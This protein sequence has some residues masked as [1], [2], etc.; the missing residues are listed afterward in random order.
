M[1]VFQPERRVPASHENSLVCAKL[2]SVHQDGD[3]CENVSAAQTIQVEQNIT[4]MARELYA[5]VSCA[6]HFVKFCKS[7]REKVIPA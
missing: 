7:G 1:A 5:A 4:C 6:S 3:I 2:L